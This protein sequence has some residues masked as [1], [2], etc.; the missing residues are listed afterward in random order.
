MWETH[1]EVLSH[2]SKEPSLPIPQNAARVQ[3]ALPEPAAARPTVTAS[4][5]LLGP[6]AESASV[7]C[8]LPS[9]RVLYTLRQMARG[10]T[11]AQH[12][13]RMCQDSSHDCYHT[14]LLMPVR[15]V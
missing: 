9:A 8:L 13:T 2:N 5:S 11:T 14:A 4:L 10:R 12:G 6:R 3:A 1:P 15:S 7:L